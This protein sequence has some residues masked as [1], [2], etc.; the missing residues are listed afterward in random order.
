MQGRRGVR[1]LADRHGRIDRGGQAQRVG[2]PTNAQFGLSRTG[3]ERPRTNPKGFDLALQ[4][5]GVLKAGHPFVTQFGV[6]S[7]SEMEYVIIDISSSAVAI[8][9]RQP[10]GAGF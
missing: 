5:D 8:L 9:F 10:A 7:N 4:A 3:F 1:H 2:R 6:V